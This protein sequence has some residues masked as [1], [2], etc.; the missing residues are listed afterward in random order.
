MPEFKLGCIRDDFDIRDYLFRAIAPPSIV[1]PS[2]V[3]LRTTG[4]V[5]PIR[6]QD[7]IGS[8]TAFAT[9]AL[10]EYVERQRG[11]K[12]APKH[13]SPLFMYY[14]ARKLGGFSVDQDTGSHIRD[15]MKVLD[16][17]GVP[18]DKSWPYDIN[19]FSE[20]PPA[21]VDRGALMHRIN[22]YN[23][24]T[25]LQ[26][27]KECLASGKP[28]VLGFLVFNSFYDTENMAQGNMPMPAPN[29][30]Y[31]GGH[32]VFC[33]AYK[34]DAGWPGGGYLTIKNS[35][36]DVHDKGYFRMPYEFANDPNKVWDAWTCTS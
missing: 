18:S 8:C 32:A 10:K 30:G 7:G 29:E 16:H 17:L 36:G 33:I 19:K 5:T 25:G 34:D 23:R 3:D 22:T 20:D 12:R 26:E 31:V 9:T 28:F 15:A 14:E 24:V 6:S 2:E 4:F 11:W 35:W 1:L 21:K 13:L 27:M